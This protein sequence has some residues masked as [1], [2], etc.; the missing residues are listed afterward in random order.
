MVGERARALG[1]ARLALVAVNRSVRFWEALGFAVRAPEAAFAAKL[2]DYGA[3]A[4]Y[5]VKDL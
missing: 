5:M 3:E 2:A 1:Y 4:H